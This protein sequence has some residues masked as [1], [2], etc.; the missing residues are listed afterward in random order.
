MTD[1]ERVIWA[2]QIGQ[3]E[4][5]RDYW[6]EPL[7]AANAGKRNDSYRNGCY[8]SLWRHHNNFIEGHSRGSDSIR[9]DQAARIANWLDIPGDTL[10]TMDPS[11]LDLAIAAREQGN[12]Y[13]EGDYETALDDEWF[14]LVPGRVPGHF[15]VTGPWPRNPFEV[16]PMVGDSSDT[17]NCARYY[18][19]LFTGRWIPLDT[20]IRR[21]EIQE[22]LATRTPTPV[23]DDFG[24]WVNQRDR[25]VYVG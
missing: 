23:P 16:G 9:F 15:S 7:S 5:C 3:R 24:E 13:E 22:Y 2:E 20:A 11:P 21:Q 12:R 17:G 18:P 4:H 8:E 6:S 1:L 14:G 19:Q 10:V 25:Q